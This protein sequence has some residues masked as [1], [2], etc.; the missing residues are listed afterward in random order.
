[1]SFL[2]NMDVNAKFNVKFYYLLRANSLFVDVLEKAKKYLTSEGRTDFDYEIFINGLRE[3]FSKED[4]AVLKDLID[5][6]LNKSSITLNARKVSNSFM[7]RLDFINNK[8]IIL[9]FYSKNLLEVNNKPFTNVQGDLKTFYGMVRARVSNELRDVNKFDKE[10]KTIIRGDAEEKDADDILGRTFNSYYKWEQE[11]DNKFTGALDNFYKNELSRIKL[12]SKDYWV[13]RIANFNKIFV[14]ETFEEWNRIIVFQELTRSL[15]KL[16]SLMRAEDGDTF[17]SLVK[18]FNQS[19]DYRS[20]RKGLRS[21]VKKTFQFGAGDK[22][23]SFN[24]I[25]NEIIFCINFFENHSFEIKNLDKEELSF[26]EHGRDKSSDLF[27]LSKNAD[28]VDYN[29]NALINGLSDLKSILKNLQFN[30][31]KITYTHLTGLNQLNKLA[32]KINSLLLKNEKSSI[33]YL[34]DNLYV[35]LLLLHKISSDILK[36]NDLTSDIVELK[37]YA[38]DYLGKLLQTADTL[39]VEPNTLSISILLSDLPKDEQQRAILDDIKLY[40]ENHQKFSQL[41]EDVEAN[42]IEFFN[43]L[44][45]YYNEEVEKI[46]N[47]KNNANASFEEHPIILTEIRIKNKKL[48][49]TTEEINLLN[50]QLE[51][52]KDKI[53]RLKR[54]N[55][56]LLFT[57]FD[58][59]NFDEVIDKSDSLLASYRND[60]IFLNNLLNDLRQITINN[61]STN[62]A[63][64]LDIIEKEIN[65]VKWEELKDK[66]K[67]VIKEWQNNKFLEKKFIDKLKNINNINDF[68]KGKEDNIF[69]T[70]EKWIKYLNDYFTL[71]IP[72]REKI[73]KIDKI[74]INNDNPLKIFIKKL[75]LEAEQETQQKQE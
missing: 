51:K 15:V 71:M 31:E 63:K 25:V 72:I 73:D 14:E 18:G 19:K 21:F 55:Q 7:K 49:L 62:Y 38:S 36:D 70:Y 29:I 60:I 61:F 12:F 1:M 67:P 20:L 24:E 41:G 69:Y 37:K 48:T 6:V 4:V 53:K 42:N 10:L 30:D 75:A 66:Y 74:M 40:L 52:T 35:E 32:N 26:F 17:Y 11:I 56:K 23:E 13:N 43:K 65:D 33:K 46:N 57:N 44:K 47:I 68:T 3:A 45:E 16:Y 5:Y 22:K 64:E 9:D 39:K 50:N 34:V 54:L 8:G 2:K 58:T 27:N 28:S 59:K